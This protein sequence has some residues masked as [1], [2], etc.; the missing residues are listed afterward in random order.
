MQSRIVSGWFAIGSTADGQIY[1]SIIYGLTNSFKSI[2]LIHV[3]Q[4][5]VFGVNETHG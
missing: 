5:L 1:Q 4:T 3:Y 2:Y